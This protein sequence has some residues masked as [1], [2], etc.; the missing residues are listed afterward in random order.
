[1]KP[2]FQDF[3]KTKGGYISKNQFLRILHQFQMLPDEKALNLLLKRYIDRGNLDEVNYYDFCRDVEV[4]DEGHRISKFHMSQFDSLVNHQAE[5]KLI[6]KDK[7]EEW[8]HDFDQSDWNSLI[9]RL[10]IQISENRIRVS[11]F[12]RDFDKLRSGMIT[13]QQFRLGLNMCQV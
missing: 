7:P 13:K 5:T 2:H 6:N 12:L 8:K 10:Q 4:E 3:D 1:M 11:E 9:N